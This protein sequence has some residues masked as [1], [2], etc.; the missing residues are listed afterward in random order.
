MGHLITAV[1]GGTFDPIH[2]GH[3]AVGVWLMAT[4][5]FS[6]VHYVVNRQPPHR[7]TPVAS[8]GHRLAMVQMALAGQSGLAVDEREMRPDQSGYTAD[9]LASF[10][11]EDG[12]VPLALV[13]GE[14]AFVTL[15]S[16]DRWTELP[17]LAHI[18]V[19]AREKT[20]TEKTQAVLSRLDCPIVSNCGDLTSAPCGK[21]CLISQPLSSANATDIR[22]KGARNSATD[23]TPEVQAYILEH[24]L[25]C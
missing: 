25:Y 18:L 22:K 10:R 2:K 19:M 12:T 7:P 6:L 15:P 1:F 8:A 24:G 17:E 9:T 3:V 5:H 14:D 23:L 20:A 13:M 4:G 11:A 16:W 21:I